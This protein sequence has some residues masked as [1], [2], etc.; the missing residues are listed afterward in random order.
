MARRVRQHSRT[1]PT[2]RIATVD[3]ASVAEIGKRRVEGEAVPESRRVRHGQEDALYGVL[4]AL[5][6]EKRV[7]A[8]ERM[9][10]RLGV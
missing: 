10:E 2:E 1:R 5:P 4:A 3:K 7:E 8:I 9:A 6:L